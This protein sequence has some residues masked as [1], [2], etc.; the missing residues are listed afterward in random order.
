M[1]VTTR[2]H[3]QNEPLLMNTLRISV[4][5]LSACFAFQTRAQSSAQKVRAKPVF[6]TPI[7][8]SGLNEPPETDS[9]DLLDAIAAFESGGPESGFQALEKLLKTH[10]DSAWA[11]SLHIHL[12]ERCRNDGRYSQAISHWQSAWETAKPLSPTFA[13]GMYLALQVVENQERGGVGL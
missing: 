10:P 9:L 4:L 8:W 13:T 2:P 11:P 7:V 3:I 12:A 6:T 5:L 1:T